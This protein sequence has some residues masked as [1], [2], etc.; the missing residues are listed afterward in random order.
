M[1]WEASFVVQRL[2]HSLS[3]WKLMKS[4]CEK[5]SVSVM[6]LSLHGQ[7]GTF[8]ADIMLYTYNYKVSS[9]LKSSFQTM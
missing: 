6:T 8:S 3:I 9:T 1:P 4:C 5:T 7:T 2:R